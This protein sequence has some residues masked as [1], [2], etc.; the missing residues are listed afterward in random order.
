MQFIIVSADTNCCGSW[1]RDET[2]ASVR[3]VIFFFFLPANDFISD[4][5][6]IINGST[7]G[8]QRIYLPTSHNEVGTQRVR[9]SWRG[10]GARAGFGFGTVSNRTR[11]CKTEHLKVKAGNK[12]KHNNSTKH[13]AKGFSRRDR[14]SSSSL[15]GKVRTEENDKFESKSFIVFTIPEM[16][17]RFI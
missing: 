5:V 17:F 7:L 10:I 11:I 2:L 8:N 4:Y 3:R 12:A 9:P 15:H 14:F 1:V 13:L 16:L 6:T